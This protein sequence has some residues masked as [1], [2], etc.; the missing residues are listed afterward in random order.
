MSITVGWVPSS[1]SQLLDCI[2]DFLVNHFGIDDR[3]DMASRD[4][5]EMLEH[6]ANLVELRCVSAHKNGSEIG[7]GF[8]QSTTA[9]Q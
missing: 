2:E 1:D 5:F 9:D 6:I 4:A 3:D 8:V 7:R